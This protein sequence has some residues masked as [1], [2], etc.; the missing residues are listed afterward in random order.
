MIPTNTEIVMAMLDKVLAERFTDRVTKLRNFR[1]IERAAKR[2]ADGIE[3]R[4]PKQT[5][6]EP[7]ASAHL[8]PPQHRTKG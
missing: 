5:Q 2:M 1:E 6:P 8:P 7:S 4:N 3:Q